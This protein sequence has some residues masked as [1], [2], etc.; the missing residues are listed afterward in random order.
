MTLPLN[1]RARYQR[2][3]LLVLL[4][5]QMFLVAL[6]IFANLI[7]LMWESPTRGILQIG[8]HVFILVASWYTIRLLNSGSLG[9]AANAYLMLVVVLSAIQ[10]LTNE[11]PLVLIGV[12]L[13]ALAGIFAGLLEPLVRVWYWGLINVVT[14]LVMLTLR[15]NISTLALDI[16]RSELA[17][18]YLFPPLMICLYIYIGK[19][20]SKFIDSSYEDQRKI[21]I[22]NADLYNTA[23]QEIAGR[24]L[25]ETRLRDNERSSVDFQN[26]LMNLQQMTIE[27]SALETLDDIYRG[28]VEYGLKN[29]GFDRI[30]LF[31]LENDETMVGTYGTD[32]QG[33]IRPEHPFKLTIY[34]GSP[35]TFEDVLKRK[36]HVVIVENINLLDTR[37]VVGKGWHARSILRDGS[38][39]IGML[40]F[41]N[42]TSQRPQRPYEHELIVTYTATVN[43]LIIRK[44]AEIV[45]R[46]NEQIALEFQEHLR[47]LHT[48]TLDL[49]NL[50]TVDDICYHAITFG[51]ANLGFD[52]LAVFLID[53]S[54]GELVGAFGTDGN[55]KLRDERGFRMSLHGKTAE[56]LEQVTEGKDQVTIWKDADL[57]DYDKVIGK[58]WNALSAMWNGNEIIGT[59]ATDNLLRNLPPRTY[60]KDLLALYSSALT[61]LITRKHAEEH[62]VDFAMEKE[63]VRILQQ[64]LAAAS[65]DLRTPL[66]VVQMNAHLLRN[67]DEEAQRE[68]YL[69]VV[70]NQ[71]ERL[72]TLLEDMISMSQLDTNS[73]FEFEWIDLVVLM[74]MIMDQQG[75][76]ISR[77]NHNVELEKVVSLPLVFADRVHLSHAISNIFI[78]ALHYTPN[79]GTIR[80]KI[81]QQ[82]DQAIISIQDSGI[83]ISPAHLPRIFERFYRA[84]TAR[85]TETGGSGLGLAIA[86]KVVTSHRGKIEVESEVDK[87]ST[88]KIIL[89]LN[90]TTSKS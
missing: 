75:S 23:V 16:E 26:H 31:R 82:A 71:V 15:N 46:D 73:E 85:S 48:M 19:W 84:D 49:A 88:F 58:G 27:L 69:D 35:P 62:H 2:E 81:Y 90:T 30:A 39:A 78:N 38:Q 44:E 89:P 61:H 60:E 70:D 66:S 34:D 80:I 42:L 51:L 63:R 54:T 56:F 8:G 10:I 13:M 74:S 20:I 77:K 76:L 9:R 1:N 7:R 67:V 83:G 22:K 65:H 6:G 68:N 59:V 5:L 29:L 72:K 86:E 11:M 47:L 45:L 12:M 25:I 52:R 14:Y 36:D 50:D 17:T 79:N 37:S 18:L 3:M 53:Q 55:G 33:V 4:R 57:Y 43:H 64:F 32:T 87:G 28:S 21:A 41:D 40:V 24:I